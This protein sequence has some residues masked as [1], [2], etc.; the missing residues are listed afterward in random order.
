MLHCSLWLCRPAAPFTA[1]LSSLASHA[2]QRRLRAWKQPDVRQL[3]NTPKLHR[4]RGILELTQRGLP[5][6]ASHR[7]GHT[8]V[9]NAQGSLL[10]RPGGRVSRL[11]DPHATFHYKRRGGQPPRMNTQAFRRYYNWS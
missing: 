5:D 2:G 9:A 1:S 10:S 6:P 7:Q 4:L 3:R 11:S 8:Y